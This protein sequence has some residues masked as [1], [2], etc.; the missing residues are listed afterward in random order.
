MKYREPLDIEIFTWDKGTVIRDY[1]LIAKQRLED[2]L[3]FNIE[4]TAV[5]VIK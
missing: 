2:K 4:K 5:R 3:E 1:L